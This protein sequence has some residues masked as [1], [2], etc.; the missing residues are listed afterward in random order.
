VAFERLLDSPTARQLKSL[1]ECTFDSLNGS[2]DS[3]WDQDLG[4]SGIETTGDFE[5]VELNNTKERCRH[6][7]RKRKNL[8]IKVQSGG[9]LCCRVPQSSGP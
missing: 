5:Q 9:G 6:G 7:R 4:P 1:E 2:L 8:K 3:D